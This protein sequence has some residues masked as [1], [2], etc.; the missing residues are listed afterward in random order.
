[1]LLFLF[2]FFFFTF[3]FELDSGILLSSLK[4]ACIFSLNFSGEIFRRT[5][6]LSRQLCKI[7][8]VLWPCFMY[9]K[10]IS[11]TCVQS[12]MGQPSFC[13]SSWWLCQWCISPFV[14]CGTKL[15]V[16]CIV[17]CIIWSGKWCHCHNEQ[18][19]FLDLCGCKKESISIWPGKLF[20]FF[21]HS[22][23]SPICR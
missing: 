3:D 10:I 4:Q 5:G 13:F 21:C 17:Q 1:M 12:K 19:D 14:H 16:F 18:S 15:S 6:H 22:F 7:T 8:N 23:G 2:C 11:R 9:R 20:N